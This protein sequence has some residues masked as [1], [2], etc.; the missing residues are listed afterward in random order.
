MVVDLAGAVA[1]ESVS[2]SA[3]SASLGGK[4]IIANSLFAENAGNLAGA[5]YS[6]D[7]YAT[8]ANCTIS[9]NVGGIGPGGVYWD[10]DLP[11]GFNDVVNSILDGNESDEFTDRELSQIGWSDGSSLH[12]ERCL[13][14]GWTGTAFSWYAVFDEA[15][16]FENP[17]LGDYRLRSNSPAIDAGDDWLLPVNILR[18]VDRLPRY[19][20]R[21][22]VEDSGESTTGGPVIDMGACEAQ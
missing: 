4:L 1:T 13:V 15:P 18:D 8:I 22:D 10:D 14:E 19:V 21:E 3:Y 2:S 9:R 5:I 6:R 7:A 12:F 20:D 16:R 11:G 17:A